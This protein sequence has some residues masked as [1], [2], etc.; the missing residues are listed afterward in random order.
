[1]DHFKT[2]L[3]LRV[4]IAKQSD[5]PLIGRLCR[6]AVSRSDYVFRI[7]PRLLARETLFLAWNGDTLVG[8]TNFDRCIDGSGWL[9]VARTD[10]DWRG[11]GVAT[12]LQREIAAYAR[13]RGIGILRLWVLSGNKSSLRACGRGGFRQICE[14]AHIFHNLRPA[15]TE[16]KISASHPSEAQLL[17]LLKSRCLAKMQGYIGYRWH[18]VRLTKSLLTRLRN[19]DQ[20]YLI[21]DNAVLVSPPET[22]F[23]APQSSLTILE[24][25]FAKSLNTGKTIARQL[26]ARIL[27]SYIPYSAYEISVASKLGFRRRDWGTHCLVFEKR[28]SAGR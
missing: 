25:P 2:S 13:R 6:R 14:S 15:K 16:E 10:P 3:E 18:F 1:M 21:E 9:S 27:S 8:M 17:S 11:L 4:S 24:G 5:R 22:R 7:L 20:L 23:R 12:F 28:I 19:E 26:G